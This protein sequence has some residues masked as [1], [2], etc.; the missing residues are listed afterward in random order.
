MARILV[1]DDHLPMRKLMQIHLTEA[2]HSVAEA[3]EAAEA[4]LI[5]LRRGFDLVVTDVH[6]PHLDGLH[7]AHAIKADPRTCHIPVVIL[8]GDASETVTQQSSQLGTYLISKSA[9][10]DE[11]VRLIGITISRETGMPPPSIG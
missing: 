5:L 11:I 1:V 7:L 9:S 10:M 8:T 2:G 6:M 4:I 3:C